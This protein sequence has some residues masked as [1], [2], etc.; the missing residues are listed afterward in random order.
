MSQID[1][2]YV[3]PSEQFARLA[4]VATLATTIYTD[5]S[6]FRNCEHCVELA[7]R[8]LKAAGRSL[9]SEPDLTVWENI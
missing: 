2:K 3:E 6:T 7:R 8:I 9:D 4:L 5:P 1:G